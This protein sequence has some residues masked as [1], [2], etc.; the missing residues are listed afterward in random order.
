MKITDSLTVVVEQKRKR[1]CS[2]GKWIRVEVLGKLRLAYGHILDGPESSAVSFYMDITRIWLSLYFLI[3]VFG[4]SDESI[5]FDS[6]FIDVAGCSQENGL[7]C[8]L[9]S[10]VTE[11]AL[12]TMH[13]ALRDRGEALLLQIS[14]L[15]TKPFSCL[16]INI[17]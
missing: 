4:I 2:C 1:L 14:V 16:F 6:I 5:L 13:S 9:P 7:S 10:F 3:A 12:K 17:L 15:F 11:N 8:P